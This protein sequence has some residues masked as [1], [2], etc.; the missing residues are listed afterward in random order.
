[1]MSTVSF[2]DLEVRNESDHS[3]RSDC[4]VYNVDSPSQSDTDTDTE[5]DA[6][7]G[8]PTGTVA[9]VGS[10]GSLVGNLDNL[11]L[12]QNNIPP[13]DSSRGS[14]RRVCISDIEKNVEAILNPSF[15]ALEHI[16][17]FKSP[18]PSA[19][20]YCVTRLL[21]LCPLEVSGPAS[22]LALHASKLI[23]LGYKCNEPRLVATGVYHFLRSGKTLP[24]PRPHVNK[25]NDAWDDLLKRW[26]RPP[27]FKASVCFADSEDNSCINGTET[28]SRR[29][30]ARVQ[31]RVKSLKKQFADDPIAGLAE[32]AGLF[33]VTPSVKRQ[34]VLDRVVYQPS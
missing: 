9:S 30:V 23:S 10:V 24:V 3:Y 17:L 19:F 32:A 22:N 21:A 16:L 8:V 18:S 34:K 1:M 5:E 25:F 13:L 14:E 26:S 12:N 27:N 2:L 28:G 29:F 20:E 7:P 31:R 11:L 6:V 33:N 15:A 4:F